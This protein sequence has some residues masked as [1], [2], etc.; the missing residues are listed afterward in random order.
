VSKIDEMRRQREAQEA[1]RKA[2]ESAAKPARPA[3]GAGGASGASGASG[4]K[5]VPIRRNA[6]NDNAAAE[7]APEATETAAAEAK[8]PAART[9]TKSRAGADESGKCAHC[10]KVKALSGGLVGQHQ[11]GL[12]KMCPGSR[13]A[14]A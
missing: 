2:D 11:K 13:K 3:S 5:V 7:S 6:G 9:S 14:P 10:G 8:A 4:A 1:R 12:G